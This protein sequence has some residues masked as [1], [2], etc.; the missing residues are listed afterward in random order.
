MKAVRWMCSSGVMFG[1]ALYLFGTPFALYAL[2]AGSWMWAYPAISGL[3]V[4]GS[5]FLLLTL[6]EFGSMSKAAEGRGHVDLDIDLYPDPDVAD[7]GPDIDPRF[8][9]RLWNEEAVKLW[10]EIIDGHHLEPREEG[11]AV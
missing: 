9:M 11:D 7:D 3:M 2:W 4:L 1:A 10:D 6:I 5:S 8:L